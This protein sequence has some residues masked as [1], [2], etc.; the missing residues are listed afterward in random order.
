MT[1]S[2]LKQNPNIQKVKKN[3][4]Y[5]NKTHHVNSYAVFYRDK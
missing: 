1:A 4:I 2:V 3:A 5:Y